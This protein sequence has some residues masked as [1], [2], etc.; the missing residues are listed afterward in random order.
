[1]PEDHRE[2][3][4]RRPSILIVDD[5][6][7]TR[8]LYSQALNLFGYDTVEAADGFDAWDKANQNPPDVIVTDVGLPRMDGIE[9]V[10]LLKGNEATARIPVI[11]LTGFGESAVT[12]R[13]RTLGLAKVLVKPCAPDLLLTTINALCPASQGGRSADTTGK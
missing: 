4:A 10:R 12:E 3:P 11:A 5:H 1:V 9:L 2:Q 7:D 13:G 8:E 6:R